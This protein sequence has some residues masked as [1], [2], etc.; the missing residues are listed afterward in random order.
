M[1]ARS[2]WFAVRFYCVV[3]AIF[4]GSISRTVAQDPVSASS[5]AAMSIATLGVPT[6]S[7]A[8]IA[9]SPPSIV[10]VQQVQVLPQPARPIGVRAATYP[11]AQQELKRTQSPQINHHNISDR[12]LPIPRLPDEY[13][14]RTGFSLIFGP[15]TEAKPNQADPNAQLP[16][17]M[18]IPAPST[19][20]SN[21]PSTPLM[22]T[23][24]PSTVTLTFDTDHRVDVLTDTAK[25]N[26]LPQA[27][28]KSF[29]VSG[30]APSL[31]P[32]RGQQ[33][34][35]LGDRASI[36]SGS[37]NGR[38]GLGASG[39]FDVV[40]P[41]TAYADFGYVGI[42]Y[43]FGQRENVDKTTGEDQ[44]LEMTVGVHF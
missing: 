23:P 19:P 24:A 15:N 25:L 18:Q 22:Q 9:G 7:V 4:C 27:L 40:G 42:E 43:L 32:T 13:Y 31:I 34:Y 33:W 3:A 37:T 44:R 10:Q 41:A 35:G 29:P 1:N 5:P 8:P 38:F 21:P 6:A 28:Q 20:A 14:N 39:D 26:S 16:A 30:F 2:G 36:V 11:Q 12:Q 17:L